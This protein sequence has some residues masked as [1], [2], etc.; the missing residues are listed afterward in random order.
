MSGGTRPLLSAAIIVRDESE[1]LRTC[2]TS[3]ANV[4]DEIAVVDTGSV[5][6]TVE[7]ATSFGAVLGHHQWN[8]D[9]AAARNTALDLASGQWI[10]YIDA[11]EQL[12]QLDPTAM[13]AQLE[14]ATN[15]VSLRVWFRTR[16]IW[17]PYREYR[18]W[19][20][21]DDIRFRGR[22]HET[23]VPDID[24]VARDEGLIIGDTDLFRITHYGY[25]GDQTAKHL[26]NLPMLELRVA[27]FPERC[28]LWNH[29]GNIREELGNQ[30][31]AI[32][33]YT[34]GIELIRARGLTDRTDVLCFAGLGLALVAQTI[35]ASELIAEAIQIAP[36]YRTLDW[37]AARNHVA[38]GRH[39]AAIPHLDQLRLVGVDPLDDSLAYNNAM[40]TDWAWELLADC[41]MAVGDL[42]GAAATYRSAATERPDSMELRT[43]ATALAARAKRANSKPG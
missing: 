39:A 37:V 18:L 9:F 19:R 4:C 13:R 8:D 23:M 21:R 11:D 17:S 1:F 38:Q 41:Q 5:D 7:V 22:I 43:K 2:L 26:R 24:R 42:A 34:T 40:F 10:L 6:D 14:E 15:A 16:P 28:Y 20:H 3:I 36:W 29:L 30:R 31:G 32:D 33:A 12:E 27:E 35:D 25:E